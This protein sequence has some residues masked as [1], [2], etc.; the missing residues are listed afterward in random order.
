[1]NGGIRSFILNNRAKLI[2]F[3]LMLSILGAWLNAQ[4]GWVKD[5]AYNRSVTLPFLF[6]NYQTT[7]FMWYLAGI[8]DDVLGLVS[9]LVGIYG[10]KRLVAPEELNIYGSR[11]FIVPLLAYF[12]G[13]IAAFLNYNGY[14]NGTTSVLRYGELWNIYQYFV[15]VPALILTD[16]LLL[17]YKTKRYDG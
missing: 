6:A 11:Y 16:L 17:T 12:A 13:D 3:F 4:G 10:F 7:G 2:L 5:F 9:N 8:F 15:L 1:M 14:Y